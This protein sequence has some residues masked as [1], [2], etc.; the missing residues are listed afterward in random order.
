MMAPDRYTCE[1]VFRK[2][3]DYMD[4]NLSAEEVRLVR[5][6]LAACD[7]C[8]SEYSFEEDLLRTVRDRVQRIQAPPDLLAR[9]VERIGK[10]ERA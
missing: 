1:D 7:Q 10:S 6:H 9:I 3:D 5:E 2:L 4:R 8:V